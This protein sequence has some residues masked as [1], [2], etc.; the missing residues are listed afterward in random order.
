M[1]D[2]LT[3]Y[4]GISQAVSSMYG[5][6]K[7]KLPQVLTQQA[8]IQWLDRQYSNCSAANKGAIKNKTANLRQWTKSHSSRMQVM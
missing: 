8:C 4:Q 3:M 2:Q 5:T 6:R 7:L 1:H